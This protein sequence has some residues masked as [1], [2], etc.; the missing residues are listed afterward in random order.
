MES[1]DD[2]GNVITGKFTSKDNQ[3]DEDIYEN[4]RCFTSMRGSN[5]AG[6]LELKI[7]VPNRKDVW[8]SEYIPYNLIRRCRYIPEEIMITTHDGMVATIIGDNLKR[9]ADE[10]GNYRL[11]MVRPLLEG[12]S[13][14][15][16]E[17]RPH[18]ITIEE[19]EE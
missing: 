17:P 13:R 2:T 14:T 15:E 8:I 12:E 3:K 9:L 4:G 1:S 11:R 19:P 18:K 7:P 10:I 6:M 5:K 16:D